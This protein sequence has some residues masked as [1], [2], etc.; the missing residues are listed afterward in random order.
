MTILNKICSVITALA[1]LI[2][3]F[4]LRGTDGLLLSF[5]VE[6]AGVLTIW[7]P[8]RAGMF[9]FLRGKHLSDPDNYPLSGYYKDTPPDLTILAGWIILFI[10]LIYKLAEY[11][12]LKR[13]HSIT[14]VFY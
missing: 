8:E 12:L 14:T 3:C 13:I 2:C 4:V 10:P 11:F 6:F 7:F 9:Y 5:I 1:I